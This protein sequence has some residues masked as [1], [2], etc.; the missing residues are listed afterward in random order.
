MWEDRIRGCRYES[1]TV[2]PKDKKV[3]IVYKTLIGG[4]EARI[5]MSHGGMSATDLLPRPSRAQHP[6]KRTHK[7]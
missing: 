3:Y 4:L 7:Q 6:Q 2:H 5:T 1:E